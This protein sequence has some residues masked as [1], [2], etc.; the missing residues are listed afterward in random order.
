MFNS[1]VGSTT[2]RRLNLPLTVLCAGVRA[3]VSLKTFLCNSQSLSDCCIIVSVKTKWMIRQSHTL[4][5]HESSQSAAGASETNQ[6]VIWR[7]SRWWSLR[8]YLM[9]SQADGAHREYLFRGRQIREILSVTTA[10]VKWPAHIPFN[11]TVVMSLAGVSGRR[12]A[13]IRRRSDTNRITR[14]TTVYIV[15]VAAESGRVW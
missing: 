13:W 5:P 12:H 15:L 6:H 3:V 4:F 7:R 2:F 14:T 9:K 8:L 1:R 11:E 10:S